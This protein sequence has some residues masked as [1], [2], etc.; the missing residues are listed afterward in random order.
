MDHRGMVGAGRGPNFTTTLEFNTRD[1]LKVST[2][3]AWDRFGW[4]EAA[5]WLTDTKSEATQASDGPN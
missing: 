1:A 3:A 2:A 4:D 5:E